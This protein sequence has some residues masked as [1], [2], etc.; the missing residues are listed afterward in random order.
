M[1]G[2]YEKGHSAVSTFGIR[3]GNTATPQ[4]QSRGTDFCVCQSEPAD[5]CRM[6]SARPQLAQFSTSSSLPAPRRQA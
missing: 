1:T 6:S 3:I 4:S 5:R 2:V